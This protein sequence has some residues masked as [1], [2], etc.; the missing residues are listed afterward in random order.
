MENNHKKNIYQIG[1]ANKNKDLLK[2][3]NNSNSNDKK[4][5]NLTNI[6]QN[7]N[8]KINCQTFSLDKLPKIESIYNKIKISDFLF[9]KEK[10]KPKFK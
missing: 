7:N 4:E 5:I 8:I 1:K 2:N 6:S 3:T 10:M 9:F